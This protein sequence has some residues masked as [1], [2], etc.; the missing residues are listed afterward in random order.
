M[1]RIP[2]QSQI[3]L[4]SFFYDCDDSEGVFK[5]ENE[6]N[7]LYLTFI[8][9]FHNG[10]KDC[11]KWISGI[12]FFWWIRNNRCKEENCQYHKECLTWVF[13]SF[14]EYSEE[15]IDDF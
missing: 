7:I 9:S 6:K 1:K 15:K 13:D 4:D 2:K 14:E 10:L 8:I 12:S 11:L 5:C 3:W